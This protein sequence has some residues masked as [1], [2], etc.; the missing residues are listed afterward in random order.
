MSN[1]TEESMDH[2]D[3]HP[4]H[5][6]LLS[7]DDEA[8]YEDPFRHRIKMSPLRWLR[9]YLLSPILVPIRLT[10]LL[11]ATILAWVVSSVSLFG[12]SE[13]EKLNQP[14]RGWRCANKAVSSFFARMAFR[15]AGFHMVEVIG[16]MASPEEAP[17]L[18]AAPHSTF[19]DGFVVFWSG[20]PYIVSRQENKQIP[21]L[22]KCIEFSQ[23]LFVSREDPESRQKTV[24][25]IIYRSQN[26]GKWPRLLIFPEGSCSNRKAL[27]T[28][29]PG[30]F[31]PGKPVQPVL[32]RYPNDVDTVTWTWNQPHGAKSI[33]WLTLTQPF[34]RASLEFLPVYAPSNEEIAD[35]KLYANNVR[36]IMAKALK[37]PTNDLTFEEVKR[38]YGKKYKQKRKQSK[39][40]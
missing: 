35:S 5:I 23:S 24:R 39:Y 28:F 14:L 27:M 20:T 32:I 8:S 12:L 38:L 2:L 34:S 4:D 29:K 9:T 25:Q 16:T 18:V 33:L 37:V 1:T 10:L 36:Q 19:M 15:C 3:H 22:G 21:L 6:P 13:D 26:S 7:S 31:V 11:L 30:A 17:I 40:D